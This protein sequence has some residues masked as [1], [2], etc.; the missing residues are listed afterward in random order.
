[1]FIDELEE[2][3][4][5]LRHG[6][7]GLQDLNRQYRQFYSRDMRDEMAAKRK[8]IA[9]MRA[10]ASELV[11]ENLREL[12]L[13]KRYFPDLYA[14]LLEDP[15]IGDVIRRRDWLVDRKEE[16][17]DAAEKRLNDIR[18]RRRQLR[19]AGKF[20]EKWPGGA[21][22][23]RSLVA[24]WPALKGALHGEMQKSDAVAA[25]GR[26]Q[27]ELILDGWKVLLNASMI[28]GTLRKFLARAQGLRSEE[29]SKQ[30][31]MSRAKG[32]GSVKEYEAAKEYEKARAARER[33]DRVCRHLLLASPQFLDA[34][35]K[36]LRGGK[37]DK[38][39]LERIVASIPVRR[40]N[41]KEW[42]SEM[43][44]RLGTE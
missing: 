22:D 12:A 36:E 3:A 24:T 25:I 26:R 17:R 31:E 4:A 19:E 39:D 30:M 41:E 29:L 5:A 1:M 11:W 37:K 35:K 18:Q 20:V 40:I 27:D 44:K 7:E 13:I 42:L 16:G 14:M 8:E 15:G 21:L 43:R 6:K 10:E 9:K 28:G 2:K 33:M 34:V 38:G 32:K 23:A